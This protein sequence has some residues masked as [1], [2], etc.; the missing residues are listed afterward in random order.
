MCLSLTPLPLVDVLQCPKDKKLLSG[1]CTVNKGTGRLN[2][3]LA[4][5]VFT[6]GGSNSTQVAVLCSTDSNDANAV[7][8]YALCC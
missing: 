5:S 2:R 4:E 6:K 7:F 1:F 3:P 8:A